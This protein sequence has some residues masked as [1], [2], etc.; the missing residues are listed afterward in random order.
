[1]VPLPAVGL[2]LAMAGRRCP[3]RCCAFT[4]IVEGI[5]MTAYR[6]SGLFAVFCLLLAGV[7]VAAPASSPAEKQARSRQAY[8]KVAEVL[9]HPRCMN[10]HTATEFP[11]Q[12]DDRHRH[13]Q[14]VI[15]GLANSGAPTMQCASCHQAKNSQ[16]GKVPGAP[17]W[18]LAPLSM[19]WEHLKTDG[20]L[21]RALLN[22]KN[23]G[24]RDV[25]KLVAHMTDDALVQWAWT[26]GAR[27]APP[28]T[29]QEF[30][31]VVKVWADNGAACP[32]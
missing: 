7:S 23:N 19:A 10:C 2:A 20:D 32:K 14:M 3:R 31:Q 18:Q 27:N 15:R 12:G 6:T 9:R 8:Q 22:P 17:H 24:K 5:H 28:L 30:H 29:Q 13:H 16:D 21:C 11:R 26:P 4:S 1:M 25:P